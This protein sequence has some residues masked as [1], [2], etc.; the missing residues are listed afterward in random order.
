M[1]LLKKISMALTGAAALAICS[2]AAVT[3]YAFERVELTDR[4]SEMKDGVLNVIADEIYAE[5]GETVKYQVVVQNNTGYSSM[6]LGL[7]YEEVLP[8]KKDTAGNLLIE[9]GNVSLGMSLISDLNETK[10]IVSYGATKE[11]LNTLN[12]V[13]YTIQFDVP[14]DAADGTVYPLKLVMEDV[15]D[16]QQED[17]P[18]K[19]VDGWITVRKKAVTTT[20]TVPTTTTSTTTSTSIT[21]TTTSPTITTSTS[22]SSSVTTTS[23]TTTV[24][25]TS[26]VPEPPPVTTTLTVQTTEPKTSK[27]GRD[28]NPDKDKTVTTAAGGKKSGSVQTGDVTPGVAVAA[29]LLAVGTGAVMLPRKKH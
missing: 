29:L 26:F 17:I 25:T 15:F 9:M 1:S 22:T 13:L 6:G 16:D 23:T 20:V 11:S 5:P 28:I 27:T 24:T 7:Y 14:A 18:Y 8:P 21:T 2:A 3:A 4:A 12:G 19:T 10:R